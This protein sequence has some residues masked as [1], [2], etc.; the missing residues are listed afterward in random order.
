VSETLLDRLLVTLDE[1]A[2]SDGNVFAPPVALL[3]PDKAR[4]WESVIEQLRVRRRVLTLGSHEP[5][6]WSGP[7]IW[8]RCVVAGTVMV[9]GPVGLPIVYLPDVSRDDLRSVAA[10][11]QRLAPLGSL[12]HRSQWFT[13]ANGKDW[14]V[15]A[16]LANQDRGFGL[17]VAADDGTG[18]ALIAALPHLLREPL[19]RLTGR[20]IDATFVN[21]LLNP[22]LTGL[23]LRWIN[24]PAGLKAELEGPGWAAFL[25]QCEA[26][27]K[28]NP[29]NAGVVDAA[30]RLG[31]GAGT[32]GQ[33]WQR[34]REAPE[35]YPAI[36]DRLHDA[37]PDHLFT[38]SG[39]A[40]P[41]ENE[42][43]EDQLRA[44]LLDLP[45]LTEGGARTEVAR[46]EEEH[47]ARRGSVWARLGRSPLALATEHLADVAQRCAA[48]QAAGDA[49]KLCSHYAAEGWRADLA[50]AQALAEVDRPSD[51]KAIAAALDAVYRPWLER[52]ARAL[53]DAIGP[54]A[55]S[56][57]YSATPPPAIATGEV[58]M[59]IDGLRL[60]VAHLLAEHL[61]GAGA[62]VTTTVTTAALPTVTQT[63][64]PALVPIDQAQLGPGH[65][66]DA[67]RKSSGA[68]AGV[69]VLRSLLTATGV[70]VLKGGDLGDPA[71]RAWT[72]AGEIDSKG[73]GLGAG[74]A[75]E[76]EDEVIRI[77]RRIRELLAAGWSAISVVTDHG[78]ILL[79]SGLPKNEGLPAAATVV[80]KGRCARV[81]DGGAVSV[82]TV[83]WHWDPNVRIAVAP[84][85]SCFEANQAYEHG[86]IS[87]QECVVPRLAVTAPTSAT[88][89][90]AELAAIKW[91][92]LTLV[93]EYT[94]L[95]DGARV[96]LRLQA[97]DPS[98][99]IADLSRVTGG[100][101]KV[102]L[103]VENEDLEGQPAQLVVAASD[104]TI[105]L[106]RETTVG[107]NR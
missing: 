84:G 61:Q 12:L 80:K 29:A 59:F 63:S 48:P 85:V 33:A 64:K 72:E 5:T 55:N 19:D 28:F 51:V 43:G 3:W 87:P 62:T 34:F 95:P 39:F 23:L 44:R 93:V 14:T 76:L 38:S 68:S 13:Q 17:S 16:L 100:T 78:W 22:D 104:G 89:V 73:H 60:D 82:P 32:W 79:P 86:G 53:Q 101:G 77:A 71:G 105:L 57:T 31:E 25:A 20:Y 4:Q 58:V 41:Q 75:R 91:R 54:Q 74:L 81:K 102:I 9:D 99:S 2:N 8:L 35:A 46:L 7:A 106:Q 26:E 92:G 37:R 56:G 45:A 18:K 96:D 47:R 103:L 42:A 70:Q 65:G 49:N 30:R 50:A 52:G 107:R 10:A 24:D 1:A 6:G 88:A 15:R 98:T 27:Y 83:P 11:D 90:R 66:L 94:E 67:C 40:W 36:P 97:G 21:A 69:E